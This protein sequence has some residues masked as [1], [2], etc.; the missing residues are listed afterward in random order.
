[1]LTTKLHPSFQEVMTLPFFAGNEFVEIENFLTD[2]PMKSS[3]KRTKFFQG[4]AERL[5]L[6]IPTNLVACQLAHLLLSRMVLLDKAAVQHFLPGFLTPKLG[7]L[8]TKP[9]EKF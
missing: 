5:R 3:L 7:T 6:R 4:L 8:H 2:L 1:M 9:L